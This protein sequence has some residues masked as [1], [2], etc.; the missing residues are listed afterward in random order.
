MK[1]LLVGMTAA[2]LVETQQY[3][4]RKPTL[5]V[6]GLG[7][8]PKVVGGICG[9]IGGVGVGGGIVASIGGG[10]STLLNGLGG[11]AMGGVGK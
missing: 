2:V 7:A 1:N 9:V 11:V 10:Y 5:A 8:F 4:V 6:A 3:I